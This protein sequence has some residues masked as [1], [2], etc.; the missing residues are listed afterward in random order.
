[1]L[2]TIRCHY[3]LISAA[4]LYNSMVQIFQLFTLVS[5]FAFTQTTPG[6]AVEQLRQVRPILRK[7]GK[8]VFKIRVCNG[9]KGGAG[10]TE[11]QVF[12]VNVWT[13]SHFILPFKY[14]IINTETHTLT[15]K[16]TS[17]HA[18][19]HTLRESFILN[20]SGS[21][22]V[23]PMIWRW[24]EVQSRKSDQEYLLILGLPKPRIFFGNHAAILKCECEMVLLS[25]VGITITASLMNTIRTAPRNSCCRCIHKH[26]F[27]TH[28][29]PWA[30]Y[31]GHKTPHILVVY[32]SWQWL[33]KVKLI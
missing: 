28:N 29:N 20:L 27:R 31:W 5:V 11:R 1:M 13:F 22:G 18:R 14:I 23:L 32:V 4:A 25:K 16:Q 30:F 21:T 17:A 33:K 15:H 10:A 3:V 19:T 9:T 6:N 24:T 2:D 26:F 12:F 8:W 7:K